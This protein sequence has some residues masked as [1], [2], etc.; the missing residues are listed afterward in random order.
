MIITSASGQRSH[1]TAKEKSAV[2]LESAQANE[3]S[4]AKKKENNE[5]NREKGQF[6]VIF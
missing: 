6:Y 1:A 2:A 5:L 4:D 3:N